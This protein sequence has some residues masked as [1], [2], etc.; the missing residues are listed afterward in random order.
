MYSYQPHDYVKA[1]PDSVR[2][3]YAGVADYGFAINRVT[4]ELNYTLGAFKAALEDEWKGSL[5]RNAIYVTEEAP[6]PSYNLVDLDLSYDWKVHGGTV[7]TFVTADNLFN[8]SPRVFANTAIGQVTPVAAGD[9]VIGR[10]VT[11]GMRFK[12]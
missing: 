7:Q 5:H 8:V 11:V 4:T 1:T 3:D 12:Y 6:L 2:Q 9:D 10:F